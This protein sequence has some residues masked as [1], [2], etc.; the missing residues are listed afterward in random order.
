MAR[1]RRYD[2]AK[3]TI[4]MSTEESRAEVG[5][6][7]PETIYG[8]V[9]NALNVNV[10]AEPNMDSDNVIEVASKGDKVKILRKMDDFI[11]VETKSNNVGYIFSHYVKELE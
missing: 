8:I 9:V 1:L 10:R 4:G 11:K 2:T 5:T 3:T 6:N 7:G